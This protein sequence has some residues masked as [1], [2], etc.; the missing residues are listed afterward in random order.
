[1]VKVLMFN[2]IVPTM[3]YAAETCTTIN[4]MKKKIRFIQMN[5]EREMLGISQEH[6]VTNRTKQNCRM[7][8]SL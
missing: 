2:Y 6:Q 1:M 4:V 8:Y 3:I 5:M 7:Y